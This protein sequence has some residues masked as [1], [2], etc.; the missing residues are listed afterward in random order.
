MCLARREPRRGEGKTAQLAAFRRPFGAWARQ[1][2]QP[3]ARKPQPRLQLYAPLGLRFHSS[4]VPTAFPPQAD[5][6][7]GYLITP[8]QG[9]CNFPLRTHGVAVGCSISPLRGAGCHGQPSSVGR[10]CLPTA[11]PQQAGGYGEDPFGSHSA[12]GRDSA[13]HK[14][15]RTTQPAAILRTVIETIAPEQQ[16]ADKPHGPNDRMSGSIPPGARIGIRSGPFSCHAAAQAFRPRRVI[17]VRIFGYARFVMRD[18]SRISGYSY[19]I[20]EWRFFR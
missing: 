18:L 12:S 2:I 9:L 17:H 4:T 6:A 3:G 15:H 1:C 8:F 16:H 13:H 14:R 5:R 19:F 20:V 7:V 11:T 10:V